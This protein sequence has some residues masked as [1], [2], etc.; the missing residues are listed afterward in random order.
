MF[1]KR[2]VPSFTE[3]VTPESSAP[4]SAPLRTENT[5]TITATALPTRW[6]VPRTVGE[7]VVPPLAQWS[8]LAKTEFHQWTAVR[9]DLQG[10]DWQTQRRLAR[11]A[12]LDAAQSYRTELA[13]WSGLTLPSPKCA[14]I[15]ALGQPW[16]ITGHQP[17]LFHLGVWY[18]NLLTARAA[19]DAGALG[20]NLIVDSDLVASGGLRVPT[21][22][23]SQ[24]A[25]DTVPF[26]AARGPWEEVSVTDTAGL[27]AAADQIQQHLAPLGIV[28][29]LYNLWPVVQRTARDSGH[30]AH[31]LIAARLALE[32]SLGVTNYELPLSR[33]CE[34]EPFRWFVAHLLLHLPQFVALYNH[35]VRNYRDQHRIRSTTHPVP[36]LAAPTTAGSADQW[37]EAPFWV[38]RAGAQRRQRLFARQH[39]QTIELR[40]E[41]VILGTLPLPMNHEPL[42]QMVRA[43]TLLAE[44][45]LRIR[46]RALT[47]TLFARVHLGDLFVHGIGGAKYDEMT[48]QLI[49]L[50]YG[51]PVPALAVATATR[52]LPIGEPKSAAESFPSLA[53]L[54]HL[55][56]DLVFC[57]ERHLPDSATPAIEA[58]RLEKFALIAESQAYRR[59]ERQDSA[60][61]ARA[62]HRRLRDLSAALQPAVAAER[63]RL[64]AL[65]EAAQAAQDQQRIRRNREYSWVL[66]PQASLAELVQSIS[67]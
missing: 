17:E 67:P 26:I 24:L 55:Q 2:E 44:S 27:A 45:G 65:I 52:F 59:G 35:I 54:A 60:E 31:G 64:A 41:H 62:R 58:L 40:D 30:L 34:T 18:K 8:T 43:L 19:A 48:N 12:A 11:A 10:R 15:E 16:M 32:T 21:G 29:V 25:L 20:L 1:V 49:H 39:E 63:T 6:R 3:S 53:E 14:P 9:G 22:T 46:T 13:T 28:P 51:V 4:G 36:D 33:L 56:R 50:F 23:I 5:S 37:Y 42:D 47:T 61:V 57:P 38:W 7:L 66:F